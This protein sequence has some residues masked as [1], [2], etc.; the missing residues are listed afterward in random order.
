MDPISI[1]QKPVAGESIIDTKLSGSKLLGRR[2]GR[3]KLYGQRR[4]T[5][6]ENH[7]FIRSICSSG[8]ETTPKLPKWSVEYAHW[9]KNGKSSKRNAYRD[10]EKHR[11]V[12][13]LSMSWRAIFDI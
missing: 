12:F 11:A 2:I 13:E 9:D 8:M 7:S 6:E 1:Y 10:G 5:A 3:R 4:S